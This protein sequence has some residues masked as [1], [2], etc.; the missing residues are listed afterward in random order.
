[1]ALNLQVGRHS[2]TYQHREI[3]A[4]F[5]SKIASDKVTT[6][7]QRNGHLKQPNR[8]RGSTGGS[9]L[10]YIGSWAARPR[11]GPEAAIL[12]AG[13]YSG[14]RRRTAKSHRRVSGVFWGTIAVNT[15]CEAFEL[16]ARSAANWRWR[17]PF[18][19]PAVGLACRTAE[20]ERV[21]TT[22]SARET[23]THSCRAICVS[24]LNAATAIVYNTLDMQKPIDVAIFIVALPSP[25]SFSNTGLCSSQL[26]VG[27]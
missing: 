13:L 21:E 19:R 3:G 25:T 7:I 23:V 9:A 16:Q 2:S 10:S 4:S 8:S 26:T 17:F 11:E 12:G 27:A 18:A 5:T 22:T 15:R 20:A 14:G 6:A 1:M 24:P